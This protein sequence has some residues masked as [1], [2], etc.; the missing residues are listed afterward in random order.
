[1]L[2]TVLG[3]FP[4]MAANR[5]RLHLPEDLPMARVDGVQIAQVLWNLLN[6]ACKYSPP[7]SPVEVTAA[8]KDGHLQVE[9]RDHGPGVSPA[10]QEQIF[11]RFYRSGDVAC[12]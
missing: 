9:V 12:G 7:A 4:R 8:K 1:M 11:R 5:I 6:N 2:S 3:C 10:E